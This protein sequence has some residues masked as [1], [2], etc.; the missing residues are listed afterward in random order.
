MFGLS[1]VKHRISSDFCA[2]LYITYYYVFTLHIQIMSQ[3]LVF[4]RFQNKFFPYGKTKFKTDAV[5]LSD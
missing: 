1:L 2:T 3:E 5:N 4:R